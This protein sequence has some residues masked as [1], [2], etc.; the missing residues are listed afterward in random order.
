VK[1]DGQA[2]HAKTIGFVHPTTHQMMVFDSELPNYF[3]E[4]IKKCSGLN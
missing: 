1:H 3:K 2:L 4:L